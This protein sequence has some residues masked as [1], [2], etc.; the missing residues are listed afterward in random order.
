MNIKDAPDAQPQQPQLIIKEN[1][2]IPLDSHVQTGSPLTM[3]ITDYNNAGQN[4]TTFGTKVTRSPL[5][6][7]ACNSF[8]RNTT[9]IQPDTIQQ[10][11]QVNYY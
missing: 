2:K 6:T 1:C 9:V 10:I 11:N 7:V 3:V 4:Y 8:S 5:A